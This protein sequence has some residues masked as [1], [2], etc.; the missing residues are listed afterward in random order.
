MADEKAKVEDLE[1]EFKA[2]TTQLKTVTDE[3]KRFG[4]QLQTEMKNLGKGSEE[5]K[6]SVDK[7]L[8]E[9]N[10]VKARLTDIEQKVVRRGN[11][12]AEQHK[13]VGDIVLENESVKALMTSKRGKAS[14]E[15]EHKT[16]LSATGTWGSTASVSN[17]LIAAD[18][19]SMVMLPMRRMTVRDL[20]TPGQTNSNNIE[21]ARQVTFTNSAAVVA[22]NTTK[23]TSDLTFDLVNA[24]VR[25]IAHLMF[26]SRQIL[27]DA[28]Q[29][30]SVIEQQMTYG[31]M[32]AEEAELLLGDG[33]GQH[34][35][36]IVPQATAYSGAFA[37]TGETA[38]DRL[39]LAAL[40]ATLALLP[41]T[42]YVL[43]PTD[44]AKIETLK[45]GMGR[46]LVGDPQ[47][48]IDRRLWSL[49][50]VESIAMTAGTFLAGAFFGG[51]QIFDRMTAEFLISTEDSTN[52]QKNMVT[53]RSE[54]RLALAVYR[55]TAFITG[56]LP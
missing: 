28:P 32:L 11:G 1:V 5:T 7:T 8:T 44:W 55:P 14:I 17:S 10:E 3:V 2:A 50:V 37:I 25:T 20:I 41:S 49:P 26:A 36:G 24:P 56:T 33:T 53:L 42:G 31:L 4:E 9:M 35:L 21:Y 16:V 34:I 22:E 52:F 29:L 39:R 45:D 18:R 13:S 15:V 51:A 54:E 43:H 38:I 46:Y 27:D 48:R 19:Q 40:Q 30:R 23:A 47:G 6:A 12:G